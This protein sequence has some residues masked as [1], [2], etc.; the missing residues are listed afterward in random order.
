MHMWF[1]LGLL[2]QESKEKWNYHETREK[3]KIHDLIVKPSR[4]LKSL[5]GWID[6]SLIF[7]F[8]IHF[9]MCEANT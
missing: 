2:R 9:L 3:G 4:V 5:N 7:I 1:W 6:E 8:V